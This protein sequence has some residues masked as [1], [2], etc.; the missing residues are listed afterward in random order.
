MPAR[1]DDPQAARWTS[2]D[3]PKGRLESFRE[4]L[5]VVEEAEPY[6]S[7][8]NLVECDRAELVLNLSCRG[9]GS[10]TVAPAWLRHRLT[11]RL[12]F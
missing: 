5:E 6:L 11:S 3:A 2:A 4:L 9:L 12:G 8:L 10:A 7:A 1:R